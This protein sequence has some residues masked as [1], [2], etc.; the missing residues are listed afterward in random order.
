MRLIMTSLDLISVNNVQICDIQYQM[1]LFLVMNQEI[2]YLLFLIIYLFTKESFITITFSLSL[3]YS[4]SGTY[5]L[6][7]NKF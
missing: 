4:H 2:D 3:S 1:K 5:S 6:W 7:F